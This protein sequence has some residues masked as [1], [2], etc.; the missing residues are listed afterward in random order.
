MDF[1]FKNKM[2]ALTDSDS[3]EDETLTLR[4]QEAVVTS[5]THKLCEGTKYT[6]SV[7]TRFSYFICGA[8]DE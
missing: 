6:N 1:L 8:L 7:F 3:S 5:Y 4:L 2:A